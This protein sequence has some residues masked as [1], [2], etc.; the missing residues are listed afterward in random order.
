MPFLTLLLT[1]WL[2]LVELNC[3]NLFDCLHD[4]GKN[5]YEYL[6]T[7]TRKWDRGKYWKKVNRVAQTI[8]SCGDE[9]DAWQLPDLVTLC[10][11]ENDTV[12]HDL[13]KRSLL[14][15]AGYEYIMTDSEDERGIDVALLYSPFSFRLLSHYALRVEPPEGRHATRD[16]LYA[17]GLVISEDTLHVMVVH[18]PSRVDGEKQTRPY[19]MRVAERIVGAVDSLRSVDPQAQ[20]LLAGDFNDYA[21]DSAMVY[22]SRHGLADVSEGASGSHGAK[23]TYK[24][25]GKWG[26][27]DHIL[28]SQSLQER[29]ENCYIHDSLFLLEDDE[30]YG[31]VQP[32]RN[33]VGMRYHRGY[34]DHLPLVARFRLTE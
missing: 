17:K 9:D 22:L 7:S 16:I 28:V 6:P 33:Y 23:G 12:L 10:E 14:R 20:V 24:Y 4:E 25:K 3:E 26:S 13:V 8:L 30:W 1:S 29:L 32:K 18:A 21:T 27:L 5:D 34:S 31:G 15:N 11:V 2:T 19:R